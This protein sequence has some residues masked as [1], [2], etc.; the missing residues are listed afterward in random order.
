MSELLFP[1]SWGCMNGVFVKS[2]GFSCIKILYLEMCVY[3]ET[4]TLLGL[5]WY[6]L[7]NFNEN[8]VSIRSASFFV[9]QWNSEMLYVMYF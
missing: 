6:L 7:L 8:P 5:W 4:G 2:V 9:Y 1:M 3:K